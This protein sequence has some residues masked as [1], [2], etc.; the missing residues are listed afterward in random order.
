MKRSRKLFKKRVSSAEKSHKD[1]M[2]RTRTKRN[3]NT[4]KGS[5]SAFKGIK[6]GKHHSQQ[7]KKQILNLCIGFAIVFLV[8]LF[9]SLF[10][11]DFDD[12]E[13]ASSFRDG[14]GK[15]DDAHDESG[16][17]RRNREEEKDKEKNRSVKD[18]EKEEEYSTRSHRRNGSRL[19]SALT[20]NA[21]FD[22]RSSFAQSFALSKGNGRSFP[23][24][25]VFVPFLFAR[26]LRLFQ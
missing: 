11:Y 17:K 10:V 18:V 2:L 6:G 16:R 1:T 25:Y 7:K 23:Y 8:G 14:K 19:G 12:L 26:L 24:R 13:D 21:Q 20:P 15:L 22:T 3:D 9:F 5:G 4:I